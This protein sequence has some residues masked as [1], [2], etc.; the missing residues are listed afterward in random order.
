[1]RLR[2]LGAIAC[3]TWAY[4]MLAA[5]LAHLMPTS[6]GHPWWGH[7]AAL[8]VAVFWACKLQ[9]QQRRNVR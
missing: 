1:M 5:L 6:P 2:A 9:P 4:L 3:W 8:V 7:A